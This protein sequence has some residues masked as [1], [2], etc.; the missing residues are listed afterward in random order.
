MA[1]PWECPTRPGVLISELANLE[2]HFDG[3]MLFGIMN[4]YLIPQIAS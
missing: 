2:K 4:I 1:C 3:C